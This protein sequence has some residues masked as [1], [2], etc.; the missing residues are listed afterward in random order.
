MKLQRILVVLII[1]AFCGVAVWHFAPGFRHRAV[2]AY[3]K[4]GG[5]TE[6]ARAAD[7][8]G[9]IDYAEG[10]LRGHLTDMQRTTQDLAKAREQ[11]RQAMD[12]TR[13]S[14]EAADQMAESF[15]AAYRKAE[16]DSSY[17]AYLEGRDYDQAKLIEQVRLILQQRSD[18]QQALVQLE[19]TAQKAAQRETDLLAQTAR[20]KAAL[21]M[22]PAQR[23]IAEAHELTGETEKTWAEVNDLI[24][25]NETM[26]T[27]SP[28]RT[29]DELLRDRQ[30]KPDTAAGAVD[31]MAFLEADE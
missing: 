16:A 13:A 14:A 21:E 7:P 25:R 30:A 15:R 20:I 22:L 8:V 9:F 27:G 31:A 3:Q 17:P 18:G 10:K 28:V 23:A 19:Q 12:K 6:E 24:G 2:D 5:W 26:L 1:A 4:Y 11:L 29:V